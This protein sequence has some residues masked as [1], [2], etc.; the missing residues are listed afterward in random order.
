LTGKRSLENYLS[1]HA[2]YEARGVGIR[3]S[4]QDHVADLAARYDWSIA[5]REPPWHALAARARKRLR[6]RAKRWLN[7]AAAERMTVE[8]ID[9]CDPQ[10]EIRVWLQTM[11]R[12]ANAA[13]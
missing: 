10:G 11:A 4:D 2:I 12:L 3:F 13:G 5:G 1:P 6:E 8:R 9:Q 7:T